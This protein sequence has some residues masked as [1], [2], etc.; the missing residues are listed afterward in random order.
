MRVARPLPPGAAKAGEDRLSALLA[1][2]TPIPGVHDEMM[3]GDGKPRPVWRALLERLAAMGPATFGAGFAAA[4]R[5]LSDAGVFFRVYD[6]AGGQ[7]RPWP[8]S[9]LPLVLSPEDWK[10]LEAGVV[11]RARVAEAVLKDVYGPADLVRRGVL[12]AAVVAGSPEFLRP[13]VGVEPAGGRH[14]RFYAVDLGRGPNGDWWVLSDRTQAPSGAGYALENRLALSR[15]FPDLFEAMNV[16]RLAGFFQ[17]FRSE[18]SRLNRR[19][20]ARVSLLT[21][22]RLNE[23]YFEHAYL[24][25]YLGFLLLEGEDLAVR[26]GVVHVRTVEGLRRVDVLWRRLDGDFADPL[27]LRGASRLGVPGL[28]DAARRGSVVLA[29]AL[30]SGFMESRALMGFMPALAKAV[31]GE[32]L[33]LPNVATWWCGQARERRIVEAQFDRMVIASAF[34]NELPGTAGLGTT[35]GADLDP[36]T[37]AAVLGMLETRGL[38]IV[39]QEA[40]QLSAMPAFVEGRL[41]P[42]PFVL[43]LYAVAVGDD[44]WMV[45]PGGFCRVSDARD[46][47]AIS[48]QEGART[49]DAWVVAEGEVMP[50][51]LLPPAD[52]VKVR[53]TIGTLPSR[54][55]DN[56]F[57]LARYAE[58]IDATLRLV[59]AL[60]M[61]VVEGGTS[62]EVILGLVKLLDPIG[63]GEDEPEADPAELALAVLT[64]R[65]RR[66]SVPVLA[67]GALAA[68]SAIRDRLAPDAYAL[69]AELTAQIGAVP[70]T[71][72]PGDALEVSRDALHTLSAFAGLSQENM[73]RLLGWRFQE[74]GR[75]IERAVAT[76]R[77]VGAFLDIDAPGAL[78]VMLELGD[79]QIAY[80]TRYVMAARAPV[81]DL[82]V[83][84][85][86]NPRSM[87]FQALL[88]VEH[89]GALPGAEVDRRPGEALRLAVRLRARLETA[90]PEEFDRSLLWDSISDLYALSDAVAGRYFGHGTEGRADEDAE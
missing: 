24:A 49:A 47:R 10:R 71:I 27:E 14:L 68:A 52:R 86:N 39:G 9:H 31:L 90:S 2:Y 35:V 23:T 89:V 62:P 72:G 84:D 46:A 25:R 11:Q 34:G 20:E 50:Q 53:R 42:R 82:L 6:A 12:P 61:R 73:N 43:R 21:P 28:V 55:A 8:L 26:D 85:P 80:R 64:D 59:R 66:G 40:V 74:I 29:N 16:E 5:H 17:T 48:L 33:T 32:N 79:S 57:W 51:T 38:D 19:A 65:Q 56:L 3:G 69:V 70:E 30:G 36:A 67:D 13:L 87:A 45:M 4:D 60:L 22:G 83:L 54:A 88:L 58:R 41:E 44:D 76:A 78:D 37:R 81:V 77:F 1:G 15:A 7:E 63:P 18:L 75:R